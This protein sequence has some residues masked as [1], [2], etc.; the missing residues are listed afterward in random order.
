[1][2]PAAQPEVC[3]RPALR[4]D[5]A[6]EL[7]TSNPI[8]IRDDAT[9]PQAVALLTDKGLSAAPVIDDAGRP[10]GVLSQTDI[11]IHER[12]RASAGTPAAGQEPECDRARVRDIMTPV[13]LSV[14]PDAPASA[15]VEQMV[16]LKVHQLFVV[17][18]DGYLVG[19]ISALDVLRRLL[20]AEPPE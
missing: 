18:R 7:M 13:V 11:L 2:S 3:V 17:D 12:E 10:V 15:V 8:S 16:A 19:T 4:A 14:A 5:T 6:A 20:P 1:M 9:I